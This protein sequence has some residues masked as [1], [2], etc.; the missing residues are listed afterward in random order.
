MLIQLIVNKKL[1]VLDL[2]KTVLQKCQNCSNLLIM[3]LE[4]SFMSS[5]K[6]LKNKSPVAMRLDNRRYDGGHPNSYAS[7]IF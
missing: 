4:I 2:H 3:Y 1:L 5:P 7:K 6:N